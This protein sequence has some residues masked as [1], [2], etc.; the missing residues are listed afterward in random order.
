MSFFKASAFIVTFLIACITG[1][2]HAATV[3]TDSGL[4]EAGVGGSTLADDYDDFAVVTPVTPT[5]DR[6]LYEL[7]TLAGTVEGTPGSGTDHV[8]G[9]GH[10]L[11]T[12]NSTAQFTFAMPVIAFG[13]EYVNR[14]DTVNATVTADVFSENLF[15]DAPPR[16]FG[17]LLDSP[18]SSFTFETIG[19]LNVGVDN[20]RIVQVVPE[21]GSMALLAFGGVLVLRRRNSRKRRA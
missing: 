7:R 13:F 5:L 20:L 3:F 19:V 17:V 6:G 1:Q 10:T 9:T 15:V 18:V 14:I 8:N 21:P 2:S 4:F 11:I 12:S 16:F